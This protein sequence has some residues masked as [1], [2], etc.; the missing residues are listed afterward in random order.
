MAKNK[1]LIKKLTS[2][3]KAAMLYGKNA[4][5]IRGNARLNIK[6]IRVAD[7]PSGLR[8]VK[9]EELAGTGAP[10]TAYPCPA[11]LACSFD[12]DLVSQVGAMIGSEC[13]ANDVDVVLGPG[14]NI[15]RNSLCGRNFEYYSEDPYLSGT[16]GSAFVK[17]VQGVGV[18]ACL[19]HFACNSQESFRMVNDSIVDE[20]A[21]H[22]IYLKPFQ[23]AIE[24][25]SPWMVMASYNKVNGTYACENKEL[26]LDILKGKW[27]F[28]GVVVSDW[29]GVNDPLLCHRNGL[30]VE[31]PCFRSRRNELLNAM[32]LDRPYANRVNDCVQRIIQLSSRVHNPRIHVP[33]FDQAE[34]HAL[35]VKAV[36]RSCVLAKNDGILPLKNLKDVAIIGELA[37]L[38]SISG[39]G[40]SEVTPSGAISF[41]EACREANPERSISY[42]RGYSITEDEDES[43]LALDAVDLASRSK[44]TILFLGT[45]KNEECEGFDRKSLLLSRSQLTLVERVAEVCDD[46]IVILATGAPVELPFLDKVKGLLLCYFPGEGGGEAL[47][48]LITGAAIPSGHLA[49]TWVTR[50]Y[51]LP[52]FGIYPGNETQSLYRE[53]I[54]VGY[55]YFCT[56][57]EDGAVRFPFG[58][59]LSY[60]KF[61]YSGLKVIAPSKDA[62]SLTVSL[63]VANTSSFPAEAL[64]QLYVRPNGGNVFKAKR[65]LQ[66]FCRVALEGGEKKD[67]TLLLQ[68]KAF[69]HYDV[70]DHAF[71]VEGGEYIIEIGESCEDIRLRASVNVIGDREFASSIDKL[72]VYYQPP[73]DGFWQYDDAFE[74]LL[75]RI[76]PL[77]KDPRSRPFT[78]NSTISDISSTWIGKRLIS[79]A[80]KRLKGD[81]ASLHF[82]MEAPLRNLRLAKLS[83]KTI[84]SILDLANGSVL[85]AIF[86]LFVRKRRS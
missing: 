27:A 13:R 42:C 55:R 39:G 71:R 41:L 30:D 70:E 51:E 22:E 28:D 60:A 9:D 56:T 26:L 32:R 81:E 16:I 52:S 4:W 47:Y 50:A 86:H 84:Q 6:P 67:V 29:G 10:A 5:T 44:K 33:S 61:R 83:D 76:V 8:K 79:A 7:G 65:T 45:T 80:N 59:G 34:A 46:I 74:A 21:L 25:S 69:E 54:Y 35:A 20:R 14:I 15:K 66:G 85:G 62:D 77:G 63:T 49:E 72:H 17:G 68:R 38:P 2:G 58:H 11:L 37:T 1:T 53:S 82:A 40:S 57:G 64:V 3:E 43:S 31:M 78:L 75:G 24:E 19:K 12:T 18:G 73:R 23:I 48:R 36:E